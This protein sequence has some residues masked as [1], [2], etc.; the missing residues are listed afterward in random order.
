MIV[1]V[2]TQKPVNL[3]TKT[4]FKP[5]MATQTHPCHT[6]MGKARKKMVTWVRSHKYSTKIHNSYYKG[7]MSYIEN[8]YKS[9]RPWTLQ[10]TEQRIWTDCSQ[11]N[12]C[13]WFL[14]MW[15]DDQCWLTKGMQIKNTWKYY[16]S[17][18]RRSKIQKFGDYLGKTVGKQA[19]T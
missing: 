8:S 12:N 17:L 19:G 3:K 6:P 11:E 7:L 16:F 9:V 15:K 5:C 13:K 1:I 2:T 14:N 4:I 10:K 18:I